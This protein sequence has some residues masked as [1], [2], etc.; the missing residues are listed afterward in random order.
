MVK[1]PCLE[2]RKR[3]CRV[4]FSRR[5]FDIRLVLTSSG[6]VK[7]GRQFGTSRFW[8]IQ[9]YFRVNTET[10]AVLPHFPYIL[11]AQFFWLWKVRVRSV[12]ISRLIKPSQTRSKDVFFR[13][14]CKSCNIASFQLKTECQAWNQRTCNIMTLA[15]SLWNVR[16]M[17]S[18]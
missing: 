2:M 5:E 17:W 8:E 3:D 12:T 16:R 1:L 13:W 14:W 4:K 15:T 18:E 9:L 6:I 7:N 11:R 10:W